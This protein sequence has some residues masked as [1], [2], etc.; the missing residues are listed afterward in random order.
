MP[1]VI[2]GT[3]TLAIRPNE[4]DVGESLFCRYIGIKLKL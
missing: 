4:T 3:F 2:L 1:F